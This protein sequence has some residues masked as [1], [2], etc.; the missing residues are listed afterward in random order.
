MKIAIT[1]ASGFIGSHIQKTFEDHVVINRDDNEDEILTKL[2]NVEVV[3]N[4]AGASVVQKWSEEYKKTLLESRINTTEK[5]VNAINK[6]DVKQLIS[7]SAI[8]VYPNGKACDETCEETAEDFLAYMVK[9]WEDAANKCEKLT[10]ILRFG[11]VLGADGGALGTVLPTFK[12]GLGGTIG[13]GDMMTSW[14]DID[15]VMRICNHVIK[16]RLTGI[17]NAV[18]PTPLTNFAY[19]KAIGKI[20]SRPTF[21][22]IPIIIAKM[23]FGEG[24][25]VLTGSKEIYPKALQKSGFEF[26]YPDIDSSLKHLLNK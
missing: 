26:Q 21:F 25:I 11:L 6:S 7:A 20:L 2:K 10:T 5:L 18:S 4:L 17:F 16:N 14:I 12:L 1:G 23:L 24:M 15:D 9:E 19:T 22:P 8:G 3:I 13:N